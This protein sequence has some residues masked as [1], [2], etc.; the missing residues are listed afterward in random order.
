M[1]WPNLVSAY[2]QGIVSDLDLEASYTTKGFPLE[3]LP[4][5]VRVT[6]GPGSD[7]KI[8][9]STLIDFDVI[10]TSYDASHDLAERLREYVLST[11]N[12][13]VGGHPVGSV[14]TASAP[15]EVDWGNPNLVRF[16]YS[17]R[18]STARQQ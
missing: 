8:Y 9:D 3:S 11:H 1:G 17:A 2:I 10:T 16:V 7:D 14:E 18:I 13:L 5:F 4:G 12:T 15:M 6:R